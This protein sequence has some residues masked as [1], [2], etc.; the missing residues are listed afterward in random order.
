MLYRKN[1]QLGCRVQTADFSTEENLWVVQAVT[2]RDGTES[3]RQFR[4]RFIIF[5]TGYFDYASGYTPGILHVL[6]VQP[7]SPRVV[8]YE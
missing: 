6:H 5:G 2:S 3:R 7:V 4:S 1:I 8:P